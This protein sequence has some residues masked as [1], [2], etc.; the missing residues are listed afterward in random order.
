[1]A[2][3]RLA[4]IKQWHV[5]RPRDDNFARGTIDWL[6]SELEQARARIEV[7]E[8]PYALRL[9]AVEAGTD[10]NTASARQ[11]EAR[12]KGLKEVAKDAAASMRERAAEVGKEYSDREFSRVHYDH[13]DMANLAADIEH[14]IR[15]LPDA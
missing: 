6:I 7:L 11:L 3:D 5:Q 2:E 4:W 8:T 9:D 1:M 13:K 10:K 12:V 15:E 14:D